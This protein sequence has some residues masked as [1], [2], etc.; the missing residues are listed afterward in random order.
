[1]NFEG[2][3]TIRFSRSIANNAVSAN[4]QATT[5]EAVTTAANAGATTAASGAATA[6]TTTSTVGAFLASKAGIV[7]IAVVGTV[8]VATAVV[9]PVVVTQLDNDEPAVTDI[10]NSTVDISDIPTTVLDNVRTTILNNNDPPP[11]TITTTTQTVQT[12]PVEKQESPT[13]EVTPKEDESGESGAHEGGGDAP[14]SGAHEGGPDTPE[15]GGNEGGGDTP[16]EA[17]N[18]E[19]GGVEVVKNK[20]QYFSK[21]LSLTQNNFMESKNLGFVNRN[22]PTEAKYESVNVQISYGG[23]NSAID[24]KYDDILAE[25]NKLIPSDTTYDEI[26]SDGKLYLKGAYNPVI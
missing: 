26:H 24:S 4:I 1:M 7:I 6:A 5:V 21:M 22:I 11:I 13:T 3:T 15:E 25:N 20:V 10:L 17:G 2:T 9:V 19:N 18:E 8:V 23:D 14:E 16:E 12:T